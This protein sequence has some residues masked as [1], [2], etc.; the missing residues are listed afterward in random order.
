MSNVSDVEAYDHPALVIAVDWL[1]LPF[2]VSW[3][4]TAI[5]VRSQ[6]RLI[7][8]RLI[9]GQM[10]LKSPSITSSFPV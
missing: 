2:T 7:H 10:S 5:S 8:D 3:L 4:E 6:H 9:L 1:M